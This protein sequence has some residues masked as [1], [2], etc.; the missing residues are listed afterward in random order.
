MNSKEKLDL[1]KMLGEMNPEDAMDNTEDIKRLK[2]STLIRDDI[3]K[4]E[5][6]KLE[7]VGKT[8]EQLAE[9]AQPECPF[10]FGGYTDIFNKI[11]KNEIDLVIM[12]RVL[13]VLK[14]I[15]DGNLNQHEGSIMVGKI[16]KELYI[17]STI[18]QGENL[19]KQNQKNE[20]TPK[21]DAT[22]QISWKEYSKNLKRI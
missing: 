1:K 3:R 6:I 10:L 7:N 4:L 11:L 22:V 21:K 19:D 5:S 16:L 8:F 9:I 14:L 20:E 2:H 17:D 12:S 18:K 15:E 13:I